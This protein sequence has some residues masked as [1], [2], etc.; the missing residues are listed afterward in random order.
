MGINEA[1][2]LIGKVMPY[3]LSAG[4]LVS[5]AVV[6]IRQIRK[7]RLEEETAAQKAQLEEQAT[8]SRIQK[9]KAE[10]AQVYEGMARRA[11]EDIAERDCRL[12][13]L[14]DRMTQ[15]KLQFENK[16]QQYDV[17]IDQL[18]VDITILKREKESLINENA[19]LQE[20]VRKLEHILKAND[21]PLPNG[22][23]K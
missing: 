10:L 21:I 22:E 16:I 7:D 15:Y 6:M 2:E 3:V 5:S 8:A 12:R 17:R 4:G 9:E 13:E 1:L 19:L 20:R 14:E 18:T 23:H 11:Q